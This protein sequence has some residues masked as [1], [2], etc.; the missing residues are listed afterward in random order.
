[1]LLDNHTKYSASCL[2]A[3]KITGDA[4]EQVCIGATSNDL[5]ELT[6][7]LQIIVKIPSAPKPKARGFLDGFA[8]YQSHYGRL[9]SMHAMAKD[10]NEPASNTRG[11]LHAWFDFLNEL[12]TGETTIKNAKR[13]VLKHKKMKE[14]FS[15]GSINFEDIIDT[16]DIEKIRYRSIGMM[17]HLIQDSY[18]TS[19]CKRNDAGELEKFYWYEAQNSGKHKAND[20]VSG[21]HKEAM[22][23]ECRNCLESTLD[24]TKYDCTT[25]LTLSGNA[26]NSDGGEFV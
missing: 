24:K 1:M 10:K 22:L 3:L 12:S 26:A 7:E 2:D 25:L 9:A 19:H 4:R 21:K 23:R 20:D 8:L 5:C 15:G 18:T 16:N 14:M 13:I 6:N 17:L 11:E